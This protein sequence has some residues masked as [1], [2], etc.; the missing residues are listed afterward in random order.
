MRKGV[1]G[2][3]GGLT[4]LGVATATGSPLV[5]IP[6]GVGASYATSRAMD[7]VASSQGYGFAKGSK[8]AKD[9]MASLRAKRKKNITYEKGSQEAKDYMAKLRAMRKGKKKMEGE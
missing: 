6:A 9:F 1:P 7:K 3:V 2:I 5:G 4:S 8:Q